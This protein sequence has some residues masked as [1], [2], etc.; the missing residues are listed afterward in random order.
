MTGVQT[1]L[2]A[3]VSDFGRLGLFERGPI[4]DYSF[5]IPNGVFVVVR[6]DDPVTMREMRYLKMGD[7]PHYLFHHPHVMVHYEAPLSAA[8]AALHGA[9]TIAPRGAPVVEVVA[10][11]K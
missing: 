9:A 5:G 1:S 4:V 3:L 7:G 10:Y 6:D 8:E 11:A 2:D